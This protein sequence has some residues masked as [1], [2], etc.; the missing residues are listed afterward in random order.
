MTVR[1]RSAYS[2]DRRAS[3]GH[4]DYRAFC[5]SLEMYTRTFRY[6][7]NRYVH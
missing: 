5:D 6:E 1:E 4:V 7:K 2:K 3:R